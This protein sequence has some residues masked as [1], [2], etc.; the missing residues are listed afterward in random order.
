MSTVYEYNSISSHVTIKSRFAQAKGDV[1]PSL[2]ATLIRDADRHQLSN[3][4]N[5]WLAG[6]MLYVSVRYMR[7]STV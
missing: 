1:R 4:E 7:K 2:C 3:R 6:A 5:S